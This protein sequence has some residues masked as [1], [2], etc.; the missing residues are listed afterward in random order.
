MGKIRNI[1]LALL[2][3][4]APAAGRA[5]LPADTLKAE[6]LPTPP[7]PLKLTTPGK[8]PVPALLPLPPLP[9][10]PPK[11]PLPPPPVPP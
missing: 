8:K 6:V 9:P 7:K 4:G 5:E 11:P 10:P 1:A 3:L 2:L